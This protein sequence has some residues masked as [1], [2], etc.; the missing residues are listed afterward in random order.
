MTC[1]ICSVL[2]YDGQFKWLQ[3]KADFDDGINVIDNNLKEKS[4]TVEFPFCMGVNECAIFAYNLDDV[5]IRIMSY[6][7]FSWEFE[8]MLLVRQRFK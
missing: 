3:K 5:F 8:Y 7:R 2:D 6:T 1:F 4:I